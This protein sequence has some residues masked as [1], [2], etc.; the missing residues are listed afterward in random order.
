MKKHLIWITLLLA[1]IFVYFGCYSTDNSNKNG[2]SPK[3]HSGKGGAQIASVGLPEGWDKAGIDHNKAMEYAYNFFKDKIDSTWINDSIINVTKNIMMRYFIDS[4]KYDSNNLYFKFDNILFNKYT[5]DT[6]INNLNILL[7]SNL[8]TTREYNYSLRMFN[9]LFD[10]SV[11]DSILGD[12]INLFINDLNKIEWN[13]DEKLL[14]VFSS[15]MKYSYEFHTSHNKDG[16]L[17]RFS[18]KELIIADILG[19]VV[20]AVIGIRG[21]WVAM[22]GCGAFFAFFFSFLDFALQVIRDNGLFW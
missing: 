19:G 5:L 12:S 2:M 21:G 6:V 13:N 17:D 20:G 22:L 9:F 16:K 10:S 3:N 14:F 1:S 4:L 7:D 18:V 8:M 11:T 15:I